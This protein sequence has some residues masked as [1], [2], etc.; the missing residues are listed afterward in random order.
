MALIIWAKPPLSPL[1]NFRLLPHGHGGDDLDHHVQ[2]GNNDERFQDAVDS[3]NS[4]FCDDSSMRQ[5]AK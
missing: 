3:G 4:D 1:A 2:V 5:S